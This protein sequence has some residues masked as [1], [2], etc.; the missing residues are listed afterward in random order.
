MLPNSHPYE[1]RKRAVDLAD[2][3]MALQ[4]TEYIEGQREV[5]GFFYRDAT[6]G[7]IF[8]SLM[9]HG[10][11]DGAE[12]AVNVLADLCEARPKHTECP[13]WK[14]SLRAYLED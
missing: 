13:R 8:C 9:A 2:K 5:R 12:G 7:A 6:K 4:E 10:G 1:Y 14:E 3:L 11:M